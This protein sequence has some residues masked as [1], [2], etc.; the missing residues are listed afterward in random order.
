[1]FIGRI[2]IS[3]ALQKI[4]E[5]SISIEIDNPT[6]LIKILIS[7]INKVLQAINKIDNMADVHKI[8]YDELSILIL[9]S[10]IFNIYSKIKNIE[11]KIMNNSLI[12]SQSSVA[13]RSTESL[14]GTLEREKFKNFIRELVNNKELFD[15]ISNLFKAKEKFGDVDGFSEQVFL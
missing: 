5:L 12:N 10:I 2:I 3:I 13:S 9:D 11:L 4:L 8:R 15:C 14:N 7:L 6:I 1:M